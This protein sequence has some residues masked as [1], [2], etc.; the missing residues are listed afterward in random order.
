METTKMNM[1]GTIR[2]KVLQYKS[3]GNTLT[4]K[5]ETLAKLVDGVY[6][7]KDRDN[8]DNVRYAF[9]FEDNG[10]FWYSLRAATENQFNN[11]KERERI[12]NLRKNFRAY[13]KETA[14]NNG[15][16]RSLEIEV[17]K[18]LGEDTAPLYVS[19]EAYLKNREEE[20]RKRAEEAERRER[21][22]K[23][24]EERRK[25]DVLAGGKEKLLKHERIT[26][27]QIEL[28]AEA[29]G[30]KI[31]I[32]TIGFMREKV[33]EAVL[34]EDDTVTVWG[35][36]LTSRNI[37]GT[38][39][40]MRELYDRLKT[41][42]EEEARQAATATETPQISTETAETVNVS[43]GGEKEAER[44]GNKPERKIKY[45]HYTPEQL[46]RFIIDV[47]EKNANGE[48]VLQPY[49]Q[50]NTDFYGDTYEVV[51]G[52]IRYWTN[53]SRGLFF[54]LNMD[55][56]SETCGTCHQIRETYQTGNYVISNEKL[57][58]FTMANGAYRCIQKQVYSKDGERKE[59][60]TIMDA[61]GDFAVN[62]ASDTLEGIMQR[63]DKCYK[64]TAT[65]IWQAPTASPQS[66]ETPQTI[67]CT[68]DTPKPRETARKRQNRAIGGI[69]A[70]RRDTLRNTLRSV[71]YVPRECS[72][73]E[74][75]YW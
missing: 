64:G 68:T 12:I 32:R 27:E 22:R 8:W 66:P 38:A 34:R 19:R 15:F 21:E 59:F 10:I 49:R 69:Q 9:I 5:W 53:R 33:T 48:W 41:Q 74:T 18:R 20:E 29:V 24:A 72:T 45:F 44:A 67:E 37:D 14:Q 42:V 50:I 16:I 46:K 35:R 28:I 3:D 40:V 1:D 7:A 70:T 47:Y 51:D 58:E 62:D 52:K 63:F 43:A 55:F 6:Y 71:M 65:I 11:P 54:D 17:F 31:N 73:A 36:K 75:D 57:L 2:A 56:N 61:H 13:V 26:V 23:E 60:F 4:E 39:K 30:Y 25:A